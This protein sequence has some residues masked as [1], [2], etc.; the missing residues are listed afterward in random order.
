MKIGRITISDRAS[1]GVYE[2][3]SGPE[4]ERVLRDFFADANFES[5]IVRDEADLIASLLMTFADE[6]K[7][8]TGCHDRWHGNFSARR[9]TGSDACGVGKRITRLW[10]NH[11][12]AIVRKSEDGDFIPRGGRHDWKIAHHKS[13]RQAVGCARMSGDSRTSHP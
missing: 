12:S 11:A 5:E 6:L 3:H 2:D 8:D 1:A 7:C 4:I 10:R 13:A 9:D